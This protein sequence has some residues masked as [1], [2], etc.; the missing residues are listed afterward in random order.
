MMEMCKKINFPHFVG[1]NASEPIEKGLMISFSFMGI[2]L[3][4]AAVRR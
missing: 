1:G 2:D 4:A 3:L